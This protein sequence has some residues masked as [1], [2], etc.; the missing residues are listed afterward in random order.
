MRK[1]LVLPNREEI[2]K[3]PRW[4]RVALAARAVRRVQPL[5][6]IALPEANSRQLQSIENAITLA[7][8]SAKECFE[9]DHPYTKKIQEAIEVS[10]RLAKLILKQS[11]S[12]AW[13]ALASVRALSAALV[14]C[15]GNRVLVADHAS[16]AIEAVLESNSNESIRSGIASDW[17]K[18]LKLIEAEEWTKDTPVAP[19]VFG[20]IKQAITSPANG[21]EENNSRK[22]TQ[23]TQ[24]GK[25]K[26]R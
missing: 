16:E 14:A 10:E 22:K 26:V 18:L 2:G 5:F 6:K 24:K 13:I 11:P 17:Q 8:Q 9:S 19:K 15:K 21:S 3:L 4:A 25:P 20:T 1:P 7:E 12:A 23:K